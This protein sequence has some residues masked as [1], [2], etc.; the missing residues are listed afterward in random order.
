[1]L[2]L[3]VGRIDPTN[4]AWNSVRKSLAAEFIFQGH[5]VVVVANHLNSKRGDNSLY[6]R[7]QPVTFKSEERRHVLAR[8]LSQFTKEGA[9]QQ[10]NIVMLGDFNDY[11]FTKTIKLIEEGDMANLVSRHELSDRY[12]Y[13]Y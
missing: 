4:P 6:G 12:S 10:A 9:S 8:L 11:E 1:E 13:F 5:K 2:S 3:S 7:V